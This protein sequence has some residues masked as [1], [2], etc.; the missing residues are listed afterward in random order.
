MTTKKQNI[1]IRVTPAL[2]HELDEIG[3]AV[4]RSRAWLGEEALRQYVQVRRWQISEIKKGR[5][6]IEA[7]RVVP[8]GKVKAWLGSWGKR[9]EKR[10]PTA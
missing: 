3:K 4:H 10:A 9:S 7:G 8:H 1:A 6:D 2:I 5:S